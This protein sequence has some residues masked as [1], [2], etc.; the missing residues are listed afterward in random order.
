MELVHVELTVC[1]EP[2]LGPFNDL[3]T[4]RPLHVIFLMGLFYGVHGITDLLE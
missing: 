1:V 3:L 2:A 4:H